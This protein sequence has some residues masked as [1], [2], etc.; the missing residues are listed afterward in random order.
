[1]K[2]ILTFFC[3]LS[4]I[5]LGAVNTPTSVVD[6]FDQSSSTINVALSDLNE[7]NDIVITNNFDFET[8]SNVHPD[9]VIDNKLNASPSELFESHPDSPLGISGFWWGLCCNI[10]GMFIV[11]ISMDGGNGRKEQVKS[12]L[13]G[14]LTFVGIYALVLLITR[15]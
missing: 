3:L 11:Y 12:A 4:I 14:C 8:L 5:N 6:A 9:L 13:Y 10:V 7:L 15:S 2:L 1:M